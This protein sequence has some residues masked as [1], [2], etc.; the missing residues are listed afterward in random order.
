MPLPKPD[1]KGG[2]TAKQITEIMGDREPIFWK[3]MTGQTMMLCEGREYDHE[4]K[5]YHESCGGVS[6][7][8]IVYPWDVETFLSGFPPLD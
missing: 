2:F 4:K 3:W 8:S 5:E 1:C 7:G 6:H